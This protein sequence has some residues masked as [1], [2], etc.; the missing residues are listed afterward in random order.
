[1]RRLLPLPS[2]ASIDLDEAYWVD[3]PGHQHVR[4]VM[5]ASA[6]G[7]AQAGGRAGGLA[8]PGDVT[9]FGLLRRHADVLLAGAGTV[10]A[11]GYG[12]H[13][14]GAPDRAWRRHRGLCEIPPVAVVTRTGA[15]DPNGPLFT[16]TQT[17]PLVLTCRAAPADRIAALAERADILVLGEEAVDLAAALDAL[18]ERGL[19]RVSCEGGPTLL[20]QVLSAGRLDELSLTLSPLLVA[21]PALRITQGPV[22]EPPTGLELTQVLEEDGFLFLRYGTRAAAPVQGAL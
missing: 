16:D 4:A 5:I 14:L 10:R 7:A 18:A 19:R 1:M 2:A 9:L 22:V 11:E 20:A 15:L 6:D 12:G 13:R 3:A 17:R 8:G 21:G